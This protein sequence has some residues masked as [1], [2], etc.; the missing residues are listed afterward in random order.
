MYKVLEFMDECGSR[1][2]AVIVKTDQKPAIECLMK[3]IVQASG[4]EK[5]KSDNDGRV[6]HEERGKQ[7]QCG[8][9]RSDYGR[10]RSGS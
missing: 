7:W 5:R 3:D 4:D 6:A 1:C 2:G 10:G 8:A 9:S